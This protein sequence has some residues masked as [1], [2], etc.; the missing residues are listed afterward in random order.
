ME[1]I[2]IAEFEQETGKRLSVDAMKCKAKAAHQDEFLALVKSQEKRDVLKI[3][4][5]TLERLIK[6]TEVKISVRQSF[7]KSL[8]A[9]MNGSRFN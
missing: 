2:F 9:E 5:S 6:A 1:Q 4:V 8:M 3:A 7:T